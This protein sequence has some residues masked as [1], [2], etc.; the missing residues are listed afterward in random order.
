MIEAKPET[1][2]VMIKSD[3]EDDGHDGENRQ[4]ELE[5]CV[6]EGQRDDVQNEYHELR[7]DHVS[8][9]R[10]DEKTVFAFEQRIAHGALM[11]D[12][13]GAPDD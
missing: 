4:D 13:E 8:H 6:D 11:F 10:A 7:R 3:G 12:V 1:P 5:A 9:D 2:T